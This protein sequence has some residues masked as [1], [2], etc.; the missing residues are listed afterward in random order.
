M[1]LYHPPTPPPLKDWPDWSDWIIRLLACS[2]SSQPGMPKTLVTC[3][4]VFCVCV[5]FL[6]LTGLYL[7]SSQNHSVSFVSFILPK[8]KSQWHFTFFHSGCSVLKNVPL[9]RA[10][11]Q[12]ATIV[13]VCLYVLTVSPCALGIIYNV[14]HMFTVSCI[15]LPCN[16]PARAAATVLATVIFFIGTFSY[17]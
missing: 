6:H 3:A 12:P 13:S 8:L 10:T 14:N 9:I 2:I 17:L 5:Q 15:S 4:E 7:L 16:A 11:S 1:L